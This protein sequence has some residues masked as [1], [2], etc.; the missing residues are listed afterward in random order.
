MRSVRVTCEG[1]SKN[2]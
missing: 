2:H 1:E